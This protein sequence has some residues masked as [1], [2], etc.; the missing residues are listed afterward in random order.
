MAS[1]PTSEAHAAT[2]ASPVALSNTVVNADG[3]LSYAGPVAPVLTPASH[4]LR[5]STALT[6]AQLEHSK[7]RQQKA[8]DI[9]YTLNHSITC[10]SITDA[11]LQSAAVNLYNSFSKR[12]ISD[13]NHN[14]GYGA[15][16]WVKDHFT[17]KHK[18]ADYVA[19][20]DHTEDRRIK[21]DNA[22][23]QKHI[24]AGK[25]PHPDPAPK[26]TPASSGGKAT[27]KF[28]HTSSQWLLAEAVGDLGSVP[29]TIA[30]QRHA[31]GFMHWLRKGIEATVGGAFRYTTTKSALGWGAKH[32]FTADSQEVKDRQHEL[33][34]YEISHTPQMAVWTLSS[35]VLNFGAMHVFHHMNPRRFEKTGLREFLEVKGIGALMTM[36][37]VLGVRGATPGG[38]H[39]WDQTVGKHIIMPLTRGAAKVAGLGTKDVD[40]FQKHREEMEDGTHHLKH[41][42]TAID[43]AATHPAVPANAAAPTADFTADWPSAPAMPAPKTKV[44]A[45]TAE[46][47]SERVQSADAQVQQV[48][49]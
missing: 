25:T 44:H 40:D 6:P 4:G 17:G 11:F 21:H 39:K 5:Y 46:A 42:A 3:S 12:K 48:V 41:A 7:T 28:F 29:F 8:E 43:P 19:A 26:L 13:H 18:D 10:L 1:T 9:I 14:H 36:G 16:N 34:E 49:A 23:N 20:I 33:Y 45:S 35:I 37:L 24:D 31:P 27:G 47:I 22:H 30:V 32:G 2:D 38:A 15:F